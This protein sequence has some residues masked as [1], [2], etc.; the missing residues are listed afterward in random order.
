[1]HV[2]HVTKV[3]TRLAVCFMKRRH[4]QTDNQKRPYC[5]LLPLP[6]YVYYYTNIRTNKECKINIK[7]TPTCF[8]VNT[9]SSGSLQVVLA[10][11]RNY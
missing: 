1:M 5:V 9:S 11:V 10:K 7:I 8:G 4:S 3:S 2:F 6:N